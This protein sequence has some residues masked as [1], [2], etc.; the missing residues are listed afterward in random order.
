MNKF[1]TLYNKI[2]NEC[3]SVI[4]NN[5]LDLETDGSVIKEWNR[6]NFKVSIILKDLENGP[7]YTFILGKIDENGNIIDWPYYECEKTYPVLDDAIKA[8][9]EA[10]ISFNEDEEDENYSEDIVDNVYPKN[11]YM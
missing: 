3:G 5:T 2:I 10:I 11:N 4:E 9:E 1:D 8:A 7:A 6:G